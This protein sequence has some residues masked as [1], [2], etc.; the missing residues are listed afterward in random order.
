[1]AKNFFKVHGADEIAKELQGLSRGTKNKIVRPGL[2]QAVAEIRKIAKR[3]APKKDGF[4]QRGIQSKVYTAKKFERGVVG[5]I[6]MLSRDKVGAPSKRFPGGVP[7]QIYGGALNKKLKFLQRAN[8]QGEGIAVQKMIS[9]TDQ[10]LKA[11]QA[12][13]DAKTKAKKQ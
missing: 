7:I 4:L 10:K 12:K 8:R 3:I 2:R 11:F 1:M 13:M 5:R 6:G 9:V